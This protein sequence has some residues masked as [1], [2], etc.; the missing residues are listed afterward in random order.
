MRQEQKHSWMETADKT[1]EWE[2]KDYKGDR[3][4]E[5]YLIRS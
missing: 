1:E 5:E 3:A 2:A 4:L